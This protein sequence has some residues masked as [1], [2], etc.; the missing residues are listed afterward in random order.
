MKNNRFLGELGSS[1]SPN[2]QSCSAVKTAGIF[3]PQ[4]QGLRAAAF[5]AIFLC[6][7]GIGN[8]GCLGAWGVSVFLVLSGFLMTVNYWNREIHGSNISFA[9]RKISK[10]LPL[11][12][13]ALSAMALIRVYSVV[14]G[15]EEPQKLII[16]VFLHCALVQIWI[17]LSKWYSTLNGPSW[18]L[19]VCAF[20]YALFPPALRYIKKSSKEKLCWILLGLLLIEVSFSC[21]A[22]CFGSVDREQFLSAQWLTYYFPI[23]RLT[24]F[25]IGCCLGG[26]YQTQT[27]LRLKPKSYVLSE[28]SAL[29]LLAVSFWIYANQIGVLGSEYVRYTLLFIPTTI[30]L[31]WLLAAN[32]GFLSSILSNRF[33]IKIGNYSAYGFLIHFPVIKYSQRIADHLDISNQFLTTAVSIIGTI[34]CIWIWNACV[35]FIKKWNEGKK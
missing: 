19:C 18:Y 35:R 34:I 2:N 27:T 3:F 20:A 24:D 22:Y 25:L 30:S 26:V 13:A 11:H 9:R 14:I 21:I 29:I 4:F 12:L 32:K 16:D 7:A 10:L 5:A 17:P 31:I 15:F 6:H 33:L 23:S 28:I 1:K 8:F